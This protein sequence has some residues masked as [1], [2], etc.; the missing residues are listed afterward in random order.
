[1]KHLLKVGILFCVS[2]VLSSGLALCHG[3]EQP[4]KIKAAAIQVAVIQSEETSVPA[5]FRVAL[6]E[7]LIRQLKKQGFQHV[8]RDGDRN[9]AS[10]PD[11][12]VLHSTVRSFKRGSEEAR[13]VTTVA[14]ATSIRV[15]C[16]FTNV[17]GQSL[18]QRDVTGK[19]RFYGGNLRATYDFA[20]KASRIAHENF[21]FTDG[22]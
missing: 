11:L 13:Q 9:A 20:K 2:V 12:I 1:M 16:D 6:Y 8:Y 4:S 22:K 10:I 19:V 21:S 14:G 5:E 17:E 18:L 7:N 15:H 3:N